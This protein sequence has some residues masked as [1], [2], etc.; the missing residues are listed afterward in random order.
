MGIGVSNW[1]L[2]RAVSRRG[3]LGVVSGTAIDSLL[4]RRLQDGDPGGHMRR[5][6]EHFPLPEVSAAALR[7]YFLPAGRA[8]GAPYRMLSMYRHGA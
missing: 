5:A 4:I 2:A 7:N 8:E 3:H 6:M 1:R